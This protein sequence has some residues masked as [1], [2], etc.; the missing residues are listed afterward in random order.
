[1]Q[2]EG[3]VSTVCL[4]PPRH[5]QVVG[6]NDRP[7]E[8][9]CINQLVVRLDAELQF[10]AEVACV[11]GALV[12]EQRLQRRPGL[13]AVDVVDCL[14]VGAPHLSMRYSTPKRSACAVEEEHRLGGPVDGEV[15]AERAGV[16]RVQLGDEHDRVPLDAAVG[17]DADVH[18]L[19]D[20]RVLLLTTVSRCQPCD[21]Q[22]VGLVVRV[23]P[24][25]DR[26]VHER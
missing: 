22:G 18:R 20:S 15:G 26:L 24:R 10:R 21:A 14:E 19:G 17:V 16:L 6:I 4:D 1:M 11:V 2:R 25:D 3:T 13:L 12:R 9:A 8:G 7:L 5:V 23:L